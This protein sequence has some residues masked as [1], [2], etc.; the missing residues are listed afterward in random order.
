MFCFCQNYLESKVSSSSR[1]L[2]E[3]KGNFHNERPDNS[4][5]RKVSKINKRQQNKFRDTSDKTKVSCF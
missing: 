4:K 1:I 3:I 2:V 5:E